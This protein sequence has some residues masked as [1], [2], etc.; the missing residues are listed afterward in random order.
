M[1]EEEQL[2]EAILACEAALK[3][4]PDC[5]EALHLLGL[6]NFDL[7]EPA[8]AIK[9]IE[10]AH[11]L[12]PELQ[13]FAEALAA[14]YARLGDVKNALYY[15]KLGTILAPH[16]EISGLL[17]GRFGSF[18]YNL[19]RGRSD[20]YSDRAGRELEA[21]RFDKVIAACETQLGLTPGDQATLRLLAEG[22]LRSGRIERSISASQALLHG[23]ETRAEDSSRLA[24]ALAAAGRHPAAAACHRR[25][26]RASPRE[27][28]LHSLFL[29]DD[30]RNPDQTREAIDRLHLEWQS[31]HAAAIEP[32]AP[33][34][35]IEA[36]RERPL[37][38]GYL[39]CDLHDSDLVRHLE[40]LLQVHRHTGFEVYC[41][42]DGGCS[43]GVTERLMRLAGKWTDIH[44][45]DDETLWQ[46]LRGDRID[47]A[48]DLTGHGPHCRALTMARRP[49]P[50]ALC[51][52]GYR[53][54]PG[55][56]GIDGFLTDDEAWPETSAG[57]AAGD[58][59]VRLPEG[60]F[61]YVAPSLIPE[62]ATLSLLGLGSLLLMRRRRRA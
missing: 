46:I 16:P 3:R 29:A 30:L 49:A 14:L 4:A 17:P 40:P 1:L 34:P 26:L 55:L 6:I 47:I 43:D 11:Q 38:I 45:I 32:R 50:V 33:A 22:C 54:A 19:E 18:F 36:D 37:R 58:G 60:L 53:H 61:C 27:A 7:D 9:L 2:D 56:T 42:A 62:P 57:P 10:A 8:T 25:A 28:R 48:V 24:R 23:L 12:K 52:F 13:E 5:A 21:G 15:A 20:L 41:Y 35:E 44:L 39:S 31:R 59:L 51:G